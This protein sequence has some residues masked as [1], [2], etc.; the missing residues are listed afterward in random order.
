MGLP[1]PRLASIG[2]LLLALSGCVN[3]DVGYVEIKTT[4]PAVAGPALYLDA[5]KLAPAKGGISVLRQQVGA[6][7]LQADLESGRVPLCTVVVKKN[8]I[9]TVTVSLLDRPPRCNCGRGGT[10]AD[11]PSERT[12]IG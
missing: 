6:R 9:T 8:R 4:P 3:T 7:K 2:G 12:C 5:D 11:K 1:G 10:P